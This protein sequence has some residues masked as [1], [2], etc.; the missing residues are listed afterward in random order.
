M[1]SAEVTE[2][3]D[4]RLGEL[5]RHCEPLEDREVAAYYDPVGGRG[6]YAP[7]LAGD[8]RDTFGICLATVGGDVFE[9]GDFDVPF[10][11]QSVS[12][13]FAYALALADHGR[14]AVLQRVGVEPSGDPFNGIVF[15]EANKRPYNPMVNAGAMVTTD[16]VKGVTPDEQL[17]RIL[18][19][20]RLAS[21][22]D[23]LEVDRPTYEG[24]LGISDRNRAIAYL[25]RSQGMLEGDVESILGLYLKQ[26]AVSVTCRDL[27]VMGATLANGCTNP[28]NGDYVLPRER[29]RDVLSVMHTC[30]MYDAAGSWAFDVGVPAKS[31]VGGAILTVVPGKGGI[32]VYSPGL[33]VYGNSVRGVAVCRELSSRLGVHIFATEEEDALLGPATPA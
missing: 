15:D 5:Y 20:L 27:A 2:R 7:E 11:M 30:G 18:A 13:V 28:L 26:C 6:Y 12:K 29:G 21:G 33:D 25:M 3:V 10:A 4:A 17:S 31:G 8:E 14:D 22:N 19:L 1:A 23:G 9:A 32:A 24:E 16:L